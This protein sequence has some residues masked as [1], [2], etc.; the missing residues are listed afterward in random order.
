[1]TELPQ[2]SNPRQG[3]AC[4]PPQL[5]ELVNGIGGLVRAFES[6][7]LPR[8][9]WNDDSH[10]LI[11]M[12]YV[13]R[14]GPKAAMRELRQ[15]IPAYNNATGRGRQER[16]G[17]CEATTREFIDAISEW[18]YSEPEELLATGGSFTSAAS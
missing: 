8:A 3:G 16:E 18:V 13:V 2:S 14:L 7:T 10:L 6:C 17:Y 1:M 12:S 5:R 11:G 9:A 4:A 15:R